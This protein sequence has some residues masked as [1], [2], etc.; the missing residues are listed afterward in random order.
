MIVNRL[1]KSS[2]KS[3]VV[4]TQDKLFLLS[5]SRR[6]SAKFNMNANFRVYSVFQI[7]IDYKKTGISV[8][9][10]WSKRGKIRFFS[11]IYSL[12]TILLLKE[13]FCSF[14]ISLDRNLSFNLMIFLRRISL[15]LVVSSYEGK[16]SKYLTMEKSMKSFIVIFGQTKMTF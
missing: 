6:S 9:P 1:N 12:V 11:R 10:F 3:K 5:T 14:S 4:K 7:N 16:K 13:S 2:L 15:M 8:W